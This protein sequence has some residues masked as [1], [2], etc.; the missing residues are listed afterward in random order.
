MKSGTQASPGAPLED[1]PPRGEVILSGLLQARAPSPDVQLKTKISSKEEQLGTL[2]AEECF[3]RE[4]QDQAGATL[5]STTNDDL[6]ITK[7]PP[8]V[9]V[10]IELPR[11]SQI[12]HHDSH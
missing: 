9:S 1:F 10:C 2:Q 11:E 7:T 3:E 6:E 12:C 5:D 8:S 4:V